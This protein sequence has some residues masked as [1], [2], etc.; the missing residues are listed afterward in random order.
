MLMTFPSGGSII[1]HCCSFERNFP[2]QAWELS[3]IICSAPSGNHVI[4]VSSFPIKHEPWTASALLVQP[5]WL[6]TLWLIVLFCL[7]FN[8]QFLNKHPTTQLLVRSNDL[9]VLRMLKLLK[10]LWKFWRAKL[11]LPYSF[12]IINCNYFGH[13]FHYPIIVIPD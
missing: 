7:S 1:L 3:I 4:K 9:G 13:K 5:S 6:T 11:L 12:Y 2:S 8:T 10:V